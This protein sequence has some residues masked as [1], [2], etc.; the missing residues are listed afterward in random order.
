[1]TFTYT[2]GGGPLI[3]AHL[4]DVTDMFLAN[5]DEEAAASTLYTRKS[6]IERTT[7]QAARPGFGCVLA[8]D[9]DARL[10]GFAFGFTFAAGSWWA[11][12]PQ[13]PPDEILREP[14]F[15]VIEL[16]VAAEQRGHGIGRQLMDELLDGRPEPYAVLTSI[17][18]SPARATYARWGWQQ[19]GT[20]RHSPDTPVMDQLVLALH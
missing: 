13:P 8:T 10:I 4:D 14:K 15:A 17:P 7:R 11:G 3:L 20:A 1:M 6:F 12:D 19:I 9:A 18:G 2:R 16:N 5:R